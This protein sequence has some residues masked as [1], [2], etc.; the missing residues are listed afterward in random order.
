MKSFLTFIGI[1]L[2]ALF[3]IA[4]IPA[5]TPENQDAKL[6]S[7]PSPE[8]PKEA[9]DAGYGGT[10]RIKVEIDESGNV[11]SVDASGPDSVCENV[12]D[13][14]LIAL[15]NSAAAALKQAKFAPAIKKGKAVKSSQTLR[16]NF[17][18]MPPDWLF[19]SQPFNVRS[20]EDAKIVKSGVINGGAKS[21]PAPNYPPAAKASRITGP[22][23]VRIVFDE[24]GE[25]LAAEVIAGHP[26]LRQAALEAAC[27]AR[28]EP[29]LIEGKPVKVTGI[30]TYM[31][32]P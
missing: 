27:R 2:I 1:L 28:F 32:V 12:T 14:L 16:Y 7:A 15:R 21:L 10:I 4:D 26:L 23:P 30:V 29:V 6:I 20:A 31:F 5:Q 13:P 25:V 22:V 9:K 3:L 8:Y 19:G 11:T 17:G 24:R 18:S